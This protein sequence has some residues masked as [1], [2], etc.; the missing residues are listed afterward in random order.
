[1]WKDFFYYSRREKQGII[2]LILLILLIVGINQFSSYKSDLA[3]EGN[4]SP[5]LE[6]EQEEFAALLSASQRS[7]KKH[8]HLVN[9]KKQKNKP[10]PFDPNTSDSLIFLQVGLP[11]WV[12]KNIIAYRNKGGRFR[13]PEEFRK[14]YGLTEEMYSSVSP[15]LYIS[16]EFRAPPPKVKTPQRPIDRD[17]LTRQK[18]FKYPPGTTISLNHADTTELKKIPGIG[19]VTARRIV[20]YRNRLGGFYN[21]EQLNEINVDTERF[22]DWFTISEEDIQRINL[23][24]IGVERLKNHPYFNFYQAK[25]IIEYRK[26]KGNLKSLEP[27]TFYEEFANQD[28]ERMRHYIC[29][30]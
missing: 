26:K 28:L 29:F 22:K 13:T 14:I 25:A 19:S 12:A 1:M 10:V 3:T 30:E 15:Y 4:R 24:R 11:P 6:Q 23:N 7:N 17:T 20:N 18:A 2:V 8:D 9:N 21:V 5:T 16:E 27:F